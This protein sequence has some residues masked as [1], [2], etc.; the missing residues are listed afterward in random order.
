MVPSFLAYQLGLARQVFGTSD[1]ERESKGLFELL[2][3]LVVYRSVQEPAFYG[4]GHVGVRYLSVKRIVF[5]H[6][7]FLL[8]S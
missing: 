5:V 4:V 2:V 8:L 6:V 7:W 1:M 3:F